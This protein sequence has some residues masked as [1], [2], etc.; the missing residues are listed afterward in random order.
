LALSVLPALLAAPFSVIGA[1]VGSLS[2]SRQA[3]IRDTLVGQPAAVVDRFFASQDKIQSRWVV[4]RVGGVA[5][6]AALLG[7]QMSANSPYSW[8]WAW[9]ISVGS[10]AL[11]GEVLRQYTRPRAEVL[12]PRLLSIARLGEWLVAP[13]ADPLF[14]IVTRF[15]RNDTPEASPPTL[16]GTEVEMLVNEGELTG[17]LGHEQSEM[18][19]NVLDFGEVTAE[20]LMVPRT[21]MDALDADL[22]IE[23]AL[24]KVTGSQHSRYPVYSESSDNLVGILHV[25]DLFHAMVHDSSHQKRLVDLARKPVPFVSEG[26]LASSV[27][28]DMRAGRHHMAVVLDEFGGVS[29]ILTLEDLLEE[30]VGDIQDEHDQDDAARIVMIDEHTARVDA[31]TPIADINRTIG[32][33]LPEGDYI[34]L[35]GMIIEHLGKVPRKG[36]S[37]EL[38]GLS[39]VILDS[40]QRHVVKVELSGVPGTPRNTSMRPPPSS[41]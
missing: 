4:F 15:F 27:L 8:L 28:R 38:L 36:S 39:V 2:S 23:D 11:P 29:G 20:E 34:S 7:A 22:T 14:W 40:D 9:V 1:T 37:H 33:D 6:T 12:F 30:I 5:A 31:S 16:T 24:S 17:A 13:V 21:Q 32:T 10:Y 35:G 26:Q 41:N 25:K 19:R 18:I 3:A